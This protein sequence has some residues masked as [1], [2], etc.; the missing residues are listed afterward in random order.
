MIYLAL[1]MSIQPLEDI[2]SGLWSFNSLL[3]AGG[4]GFFV[5]PSPF[6][7]ILAVIASI[8]AVSVQVAITLVFKQVRIQKIFI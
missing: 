2:Y 8:I 5:S 3:A 1:V 7:L 6:N 4:V